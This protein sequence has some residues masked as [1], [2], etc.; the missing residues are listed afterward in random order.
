MYVHF[1]RRDCPYVLSLP[2][3]NTIPKGIVYAHDD[4]KM[5]RNTTFSKVQ[6]LYFSV[7]QVLMAPYKL[8]TD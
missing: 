4:H 8:F 3:Y 2:D 5:C 6:Q 7:D 1:K